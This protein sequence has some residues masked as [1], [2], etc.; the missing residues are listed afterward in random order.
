MIITAAGMAV[1]ADVFMDLGARFLFAILSS[2][3][4]DPGLP[5]IRPDVVCALAQSGIGSLLYYVAQ[6]LGPA[7]FD[8][9]LWEWR[10]L[11]NASPP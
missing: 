3:D 8:A 5:N 7:E 6:N 11:L 4:F 10:A 2:G 1:S 9:F